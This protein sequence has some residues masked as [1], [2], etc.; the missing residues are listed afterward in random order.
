MGAVRENSVR[1]AGVLGLAPEKRPPFRD[2]VGGEAVFVRTV[3]IDRRACAMAPAEHVSTG[4]LHHAKGEVVHTIGNP[5]AEVG[6]FLAGF[7]DPA[8]EFDVMAVDPESGVAV[9]A[10]VANAE[11][12]GCAIPQRP[13]RRDGSYQETGLIRPETSPQRM[14]FVFSPLCRL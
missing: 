10:E 3:G 1:A 13:F 11:R 9:E 8:V 6:P 7:L 4:I 2:R 5:G 14:N 12:G